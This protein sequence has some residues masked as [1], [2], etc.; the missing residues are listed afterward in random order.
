VKRQAS[1]HD[2]VCDLHK[3]LAYGVAELK[4]RKVNIQYATPKPDPA[5]T[6]GN[7]HIDFPLPPGTWLTEPLTVW[8]FTEGDDGVDAFTAGNTVIL[9]GSD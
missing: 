8:V 9:L 2:P 5:C 3:G 6:S 1:K 4:R 7:M